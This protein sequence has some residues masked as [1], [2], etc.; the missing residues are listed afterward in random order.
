M[1][2]IYWACFPPSFFPER[3]PLEREEEG[4]KG[5]NFLPLS[6]ASSCEPR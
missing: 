6:G 1:E 3:C 5:V 4:G 2:M